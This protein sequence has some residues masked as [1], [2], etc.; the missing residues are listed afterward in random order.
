MSEI[1]LTNLQTQ[2]IY[3]LNHCTVWNLVKIKF[4]DWNGVWKVKLDK[5]K[6]Y[7]VTVTKDSINY[8][9]THTVLTFAASNSSPCVFKSFSACLIRGG[10]ELK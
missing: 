4:N 1:V 9:H 2:I 10:F 3:V 6:N 5:L 8:L 7:H